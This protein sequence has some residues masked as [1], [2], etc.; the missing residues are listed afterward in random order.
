MPSNKYL[1]KKA[2]TQ[3][4]INTLTD[5]SKKSL[6]ITRTPV[7]P[8]TP[9]IT[10]TASDSKHRD[11]LEA[12]LAEQQQQIDKLIKGVNQLEG[13]VLILDSQ[14][15]VSETVNNLIKK[16]ADDLEAYSRSSCIHVNG[17]QKYDHENNDNLKKTVAENIS[18][19]TG[20]SID[21]I[22]RS[23][24]KLHRTRKYDQTTKTRPVIV[25]FTSHNK[26]SLNE[27]L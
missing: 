21:N 26:F 23:T 8:T 4:Q 22:E 17:L 9:I 5:K 24:D 19:K 18:S 6:N 7:T 11:H 2:T 15:A 1:G 25:K 12:K 14:L 27:K 13:Q 20:I 16:K 10:D 3:A